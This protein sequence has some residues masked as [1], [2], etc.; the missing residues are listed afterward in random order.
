[1]IVIPYCLLDGH[2]FL[3]WCCRKRTEVKFYVL[4]EADRMLDSGFG[5]QM[6]E[7]ARAVPPER[8]LGFAKVRNKV[9]E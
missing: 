9:L 6:D 7:I 5:E 3:G 1:M 2:L 4:D 8:H